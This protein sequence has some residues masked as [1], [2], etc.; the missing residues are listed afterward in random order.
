MTGKLKEFETISKAIQATYQALYSEGPCPQPAMES[1]KEAEE[2]L[3]KA[4]DY[5]LSHRRMIGN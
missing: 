4:I 3:N 5:T 1:L 2:S